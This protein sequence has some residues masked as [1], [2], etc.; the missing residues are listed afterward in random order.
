MR[1][2]RAIGIVALAASMAVSASLVAAGEWV[3]ISDGVL[4]DIQRQGLKVAWPGK[5]TGLAVDRT[6]GELF[7]LIPGL[8]VWRSVDKGVR[9]VRCDGG[10]VGGRCE[11]GYSLCPDPAGKRMA[12]FMLDGKSA[13]TLDGG[14]TWRAIKNMGRGPDW[15]A[16]DWSRDDP[17]TL[18]ERTHENHDIGILSRDGG[19]TW[20]DL[21]QGIGAVG[22]FG[23]SV[24]L[25]SRGKEPRWSGLHRS[26]DGG[27]TWQQVHEATPIGTMTV[28]KGAGYWLS[29]R[30]LLVSR[31]QG[32]TWSVVE[33]ARGAV[34]GPY[35]GRDENHF[36]VVDKRGFQETTDA[37]K[38]WTQVAPFPP[39]LSGEY[40]TRGWFLNC[41]WDPIGKVCYAAKMSKPAYR[42]EY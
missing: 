1:A 15:G 21:G 19:K 26:L 13:M 22:V 33:S 38:T 16:V 42:F 5:T 29:N 35:F 8:G 17:Q 41:A 39:A 36:V 6:T 7:L 2:R 18:F 34:W 40:N 12:C 24:L 14:K 32:K 23:E 4:E 37:G 25:A 9:F 20:T 10:A 31:D 3:C 28:F 30:G 11:T 27:K